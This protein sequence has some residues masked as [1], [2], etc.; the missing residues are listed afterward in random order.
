MKLLL[1][2]NLSPEWRGSLEAV[3]HRVVH[4]SEVGAHTAPYREIMR[5]ASANGYVVFT[6]D[7]DFG[8]I[9]ATTGDTGPSV[10]QMR[11]Q[12]PTPEVMAAAVLQAISQ[13]E[14]QLL[15]GAIVVIDESRA[16]VRVLPLRR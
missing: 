1:D 7:L 12:A 8:T 4:W 16:R 11:T 15:D 2:M 14:Q 9:L 3:G 10:L 13:W 5:W 6:H